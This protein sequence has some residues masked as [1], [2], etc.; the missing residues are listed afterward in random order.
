[1]QSARLSRWDSLLHLFIDLA[2][3]R[4]ASPPL[5]SLLGIASEALLLLPSEALLLLPCEASG[6]HGILAQQLTDYPWPLYSTHAPSS[7]LC[8][9]S[10]SSPARS[11]F[12]P[13]LASA[14]LSQLLS[15]FSRPPVRPGSSLW[16]SHLLR[17]GPATAQPPSPKNIRRVAART[18]IVSLAR[19]TTKQKQLAVLVPA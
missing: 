19:H 2:L 4:M 5:F 1:M 6:A 8:R 18:A 13:R 17:S 12:P 11:P 15:S 14:R 3:L 7:L 16:I 9:W 10:R